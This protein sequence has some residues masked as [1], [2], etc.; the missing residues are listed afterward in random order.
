[1]RAVVDTNVVV[2]SVLAEG[3]PPDSV[4]AAARNGA[5]DP[6]SSGALLAELETVLRRPR[7]RNRLDWSEADVTV[8]LSTFA[9]MCALVEP[10]VVISLLQDD[11]DNRILEAAVEGKADYIVTG[12]RGL[13]GLGSYQATEVVTPVRFLAILAAEQSI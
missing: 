1:V 4:L 10:R 6:V 7:I 5:F 2:S 11:P 3:S 13:L 9:E 8:F 12:D